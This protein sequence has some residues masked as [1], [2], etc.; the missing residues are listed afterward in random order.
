MNKLTIFVASSDELYDERVALGDLFRR[1][2]EIYKSKG[3][4]IKL[5]IWEDFEAAYQGRR[6]QDVYNEILSGCD[7]FMAIF[8]RLAGRFTIEEFE[9]ARDC[10]E[11]SS[12]PK[13]YTYVKDLK[14]Q[15]SES[16][17]LTE[18]KERLYKELGHYWCR[19]NN[20]ETM[21]LHFVMQIQRLLSNRVAKLEVKDSNILLDEEYIANLNN[22]PFAA[23]N[24]MFISLN[25]QLSDINR[26]MAT[27]K[28]IY[29]SAPTIEINSLLESKDT[30]LTTRQKNQTRHVHHII[31]HY[32]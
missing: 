14:K 9:V 11:R 17:E 8:H 29:L 1:L 23:N 15:E 25:R 31:A 6:T 10:F 4:T 22:I 19:F 2:N 27:Y 32:Y 13:V 21:M 28:A 7:M 20:D 16:P 3:V 24:K 18:F 5:K 12:S 30:E 26:D